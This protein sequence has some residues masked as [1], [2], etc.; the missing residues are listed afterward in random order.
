MIV[1]LWCMLSQK[2]TEEHTPLVSTE[3]RIQI[4]TCCSTT[5]QRWHQGW[6]I[7][8]D[9][10]TQIFYPLTPSPLKSTGMPPP[11]GP[12]DDKHKLSECDEEP[13]K[14]KQTHLLAPNIQAQGPVFGYGVRRH[15]LVHSAGTHTATGTALLWPALSAG[16]ACLA[17]VRGRREVLP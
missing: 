13:V 12:I 17:L 11:N 15:R 2:A 8:S 6:P 10:S 9:T 7:F 4:R 5:M 14:T 3:W 16:E 1:T